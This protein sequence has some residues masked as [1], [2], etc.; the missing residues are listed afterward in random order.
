MAF[1]KRGD[2][3]Q[4]LDIIESTD[5]IDEE[6]VKQALKISEQEVKNTTKKE[7]SIDKLN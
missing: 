5:K 3:Q 4:I 7:L 1:V 2:N 6:K